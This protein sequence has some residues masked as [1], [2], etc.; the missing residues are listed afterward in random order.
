MIKDAKQIE[1]LLNF[2]GYFNDGRFMNQEYRKGIM[3]A[4]YYMLYENQSIEQ[5]MNHFEKEVKE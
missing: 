5:I 4:C 2:V 3:D 1:K